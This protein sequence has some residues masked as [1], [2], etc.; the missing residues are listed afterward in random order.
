MRSAWRFP[1]L[2]LI[3][4]D[5]VALPEK[6]LQERHGTH[7]AAED[8]P[9]DRA[10]EENGSESEEGLRNEGLLGKHDFYGAE[11]ADER[12]VLPAEARERSP[13]GMPEKPRGSE[14][15]KKNRREGAEYFG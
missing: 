12:N 13:A 8:A 3:N 4:P 10:D 15:E 14:K 6:A 9:E 7:P 2:L 11:R 1:G 5:F